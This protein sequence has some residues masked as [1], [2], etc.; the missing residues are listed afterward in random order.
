LLLAGI[1]VDVVGSAA[2]SSIEW[3]DSNQM[4]N[5]SHAIGILA[6][7]QWLFIIHIVTVD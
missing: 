4:L 5:D 1:L 7:L 6:E 2:V 3:L